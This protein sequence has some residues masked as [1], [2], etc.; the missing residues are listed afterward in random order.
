MSIE[1]ELIYLEIL[2]AILMASLDSQLWE[3]ALQKLSLLTGHQYAALFFYDKGNAHLMTDSLLIEEKVFA[4]YRDRFL[5]IDPA[6]KILTG[7]PVGQMYRDREFLGDKFIANSIYYN[8]FHHPNDLNHLT[9]VKLCTVNGYSTFLSLMTANDAAYPQPVKFELFRRLIPALI[10][11]SQLHARFEQLR[12]TI[13]YQ[14]AVMGNG[15]Y[16]VWL[17]DRRGKILYASAH[18][19]SYQRTSVRLVWSAGADTLS[20]NTDSKKFKHALEKATQTGAPPRAGLC[21]TNGR[22]AKPILV[23]P[24][25]HLPGVACIIIPEPFFNSSPL[26]ELFNVKPAENAVA[27][28]LV[29]GMTPDECALHLGVSITTIRTH[30]SALYRK[31]HTRNQSELLLII[32]AIHS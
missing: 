19:E 3:P 32:R 8:E 7:L 5:A 16:P 20:L 30:L 10:T 6:E 2:E 14:N 17:V 23:L 29:R 31:T 13:K 28:L 21:Y 25:S 12:E 22:D 27:E 1:P 26:M 9:S 11:A 15:I 18:A 4:A 24:A